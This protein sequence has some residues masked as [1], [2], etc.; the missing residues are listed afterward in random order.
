M[1]ITHNSNNLGREKLW[2]KRYCYYVVRDLHYN[3]G[4]L[5]NYLY[6][7]VKT[8]WY[9]GFRYFICIIGLI[10]RCLSEFFKTDLENFKPYPTV[11]S[12]EFLCA[13]GW[14][15]QTPT[16]KS[17]LHHVT[18]IRNSVLSLCFTTNVKCHFTLKLS[19]VAFF[20]R[21]PFPSRFMEIISILWVT[22]IHRDLS[23]HSYGKDVG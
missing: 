3:N 22:Y 7:K 16:V 2:P 4:M 12:L 9:I 19:Q 8:L 15:T 1:E 17:D 18:V 6:R 23:F 21:M 14:K 10:Y 5:P 13:N 11:L 20:Y